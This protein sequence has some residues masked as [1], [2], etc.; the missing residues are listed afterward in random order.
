MHSTLRVFLHTF[1]HLVVLLVTVPV[2]VQPLTC[3]FQDLVLMT[4]SHYMAGRTGGS[5][6]SLSQW[7]EPSKRVQLWDPPSST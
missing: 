2:R 4:Y 1:F 7:P 6:A 5:I 3:A